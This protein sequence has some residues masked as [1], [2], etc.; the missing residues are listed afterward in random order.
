MTTA[1]ATMIKIMETLPETTQDQLLAHIRDYLADIQDEFE[2]ERLVKKTQP[3]L[4]QSAQQAKQEIAA[5]RSQP[6]DY[7]QL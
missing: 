1:I 7:N 3:Q 2:W 4:I 6:M 5:G